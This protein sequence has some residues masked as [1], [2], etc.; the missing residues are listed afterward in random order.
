MRVALAQA[1]LVKPTLLLLDEPTNHLDLEACVWLENYLSTKYNRCLIVISH[2][3]DFLNTVCTNIIHINPKRKLTYYSGNYDTFVKTKAEVEANQ[4]KQYRKEQD[5]IKHIKEFIASCGTYSNLVRQAKSKQKIIDKMEEKGLTEMPEPDPT[6]NFRWPEVTP[7]APPILAFYDVSFSY[8][9]KEPYLYEGLDLAVLQDSRIALVGPNGVGK[10]TL[11][12]LMAG[13]LTPALGQVRRHMDL[14]L[15]R[16]NQHST[17]QLEMDASPL[18]FIQR[19]FPKERKEEPEWRSWLGKYGIN[20]K[21]QVTKIGALSDGQKSRLVFAMMAFR[22]PHV[23][24]FDEPTNHLDMQ[25]IDAL[26]DAIRAFNGGMVLVSHDFRL[27]DQVARDI[28]VCGDKTVT[29]WEGTIRE[30]KQHL[31]KG[32][33]L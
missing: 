31:A 12:K 15:G 4:M 32:M 26:G 27:I 23:L 30:Y 17:E 19:A 14:I 18:E 22:R 33:I 1:L 8:N 21:M 13:E 20:G 2:S 9:G 16:Y 3:Q 11:L 25:C 10:S 28:W 29:K 7:L 5:D 6:F 24:L